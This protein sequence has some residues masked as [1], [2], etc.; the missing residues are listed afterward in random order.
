MNH[1]V[2]YSTIN[3]CIPTYQHLIQ[4]EAHYNNEL[5]NIYNTLKCIKAGKDWARKN[6]LTYNL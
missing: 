1:S 3:E 4:L 2:Q 5:S 6:L